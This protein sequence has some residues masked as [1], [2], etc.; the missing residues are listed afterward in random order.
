MKVRGYTLVETTA[1][2][3]LTALLAVSVLRGIELIERATQSW[4]R[5]GSEL[6]DAATAIDLWATDRYHADSISARGPTVLFAIGLDTVRWSRASAGFCV[7]Q[8]ERGRRR[9][10]DTLSAD[11]ISLGDTATV[12][13][14]P[15]GTGVCLVAL[16]TSFPL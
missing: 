11:L 3:A 2:L 15:S 8:H 9:R 13:C 4:L 1:A 7:R 14:S 12:L 16:H 5:S 6:A 10:R